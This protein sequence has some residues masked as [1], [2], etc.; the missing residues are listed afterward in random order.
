MQRLNLEYVFKSN[1]LT[2]TGGNETA[3]SWLV[4][5][6]QVYQT[7]NRYFYCSNYEINVSCMLEQEVME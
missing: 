2:F 7:L 5:E 4:L 1:K 3:F 6:L